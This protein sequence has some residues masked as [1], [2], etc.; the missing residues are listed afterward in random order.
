MKQIRCA[1]CGRLFD[2]NPRVKNQRYCSE[3]ECQRVRKKLWQRHKLAT[4]PDYKANQKD[5]QKTWREN[6]PDYW[7]EYRERNPQYAERN[8]NRQRERRRVA[9]MD[10]SGMDLPLESGT[11][12]I[13]PASEGVA[14]KDASARKVL[15]I[16]VG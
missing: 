9:K 12:F 5:S 8:R 11:Y 16:P 1:H 3:K 15:L 2:P 7:R 14:K 10:A 13:L 4:D 6:N